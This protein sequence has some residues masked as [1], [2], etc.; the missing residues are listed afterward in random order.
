MKGLFNSFYMFTFSSQI[1]TLAAEYPAKT[2][3]L[4]CTYHGQVRDVKKQNKKKLFQTNSFIVS[5][6]SYRNGK[7]FK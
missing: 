4:Y 7:T 6:Q 1:D 2:N 3:Y 5:L